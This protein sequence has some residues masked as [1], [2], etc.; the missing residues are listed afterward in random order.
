MTIC[1][2]DERA[3]RVFIE[4][5]TPAESSE[6]E[7][8]NEQYHLLFSVLRQF[9]EL[10]WG[11]NWLKVALSRPLRVDSATWLDM[12]KHVFVRA[13]AVQEM[14]RLK[15]QCPSLIGE[16]LWAACRGSVTCSEYL[17]EKVIYC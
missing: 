9:A 11:P 6:V 8:S 4:G 13:T 16:E 15:L 14:I 1:P 17:I 2:Q 3:Q 7:L 12:A 5:S 10:K